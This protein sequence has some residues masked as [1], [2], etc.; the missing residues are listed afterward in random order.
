MYKIHPNHTSKQ[1][2]AGLS[3]RVLLLEGSKTPILLH[4][5]WRKYPVLTWDSLWVVLQLWRRNAG[6]V[7]WCQSAVLHRHD[8]LL[9]LTAAATATTSFIL[10]MPTY[11]NHITELGNSKVISGQSITNMWCCKHTRFC[12]EAFMCHIYIFIH[13][14]AIQILFY[15]T[16][17]ITAL[18]ILLLLLLS[19]EEEVQVG[20]VS[21]S[22]SCKINA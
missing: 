22:V 19:M 15:I 5:V 6:Y 3:L 8:W 13:I 9:R 16:F 1:V 4:T 7:L 21:V 14:S 20:G 11:K 2:W 18:L 17:N 12:V 10:Q